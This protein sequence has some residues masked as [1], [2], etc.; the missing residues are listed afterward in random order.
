[1][2]SK[3]FSGWIKTRALELGFSGCGIARA[4]FLQNEALHLENWLNAGMHGEMTYMENH[5]EKRV[6]PRKLLDGAKSVVVLLFNYFPEKPLPETGNCILS[7]YAYGEDYHFVIK[8]KLNRLIAELKAKAGDI[9]AR[10]FVDSAPVL[11][12]A[13]A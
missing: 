12:R 6:D 9:N 8:E 4:G 5:F 7:K 2:N 13:W 3:E 10:P 11:E 1:M